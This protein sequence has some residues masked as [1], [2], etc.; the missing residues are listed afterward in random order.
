MPRASP[1]SREDNGKISG[2][3]IGPQSWVRTDGSGKTCPP[4]VQLCSVL[5]GTEG[6]RCW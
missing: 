2:G 6:L 3:P 4:R 5:A 1:G